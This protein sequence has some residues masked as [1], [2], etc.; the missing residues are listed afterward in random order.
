M[1]VDAEQLVTVLVAVSFLVTGFA[2]GFFYAWI[3]T[4][5]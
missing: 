2:L 1:T 5:K 3:R 4:L